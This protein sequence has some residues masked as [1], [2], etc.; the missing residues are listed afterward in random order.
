MLDPSLTPW[1]NIYNVRGD[2]GGEPPERRR[3]RRRR[4]E[5]T[6]RPVE[7]ESKTARLTLGPH[8]KREKQVILWK[9]PSPTCP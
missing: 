5:S 9:M 1:V 6:P 2:R 3:R 8:K 4:K 7:V